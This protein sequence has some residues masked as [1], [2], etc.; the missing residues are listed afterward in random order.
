[1][2]SNNKNPTFEM[3]LGSDSVIQTIL[4]TGTP[5]E[6]GLKAVE[7]DFSD[8]EYNKMMSDFLQKMR[9]QAESLNKTPKEKIQTIR[10]QLADG[11]K[12]LKFRKG[13]L[14]N[15]TSVG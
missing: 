13:F 3:T 4:E 6:N 10:E 2:D 14:N 12:P 8:E 5:A 9:V 7:T 1:M 15:H 11:R